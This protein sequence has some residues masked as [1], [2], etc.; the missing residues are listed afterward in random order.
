VR[1]YQPR[2]RSTAQRVRGSCSSR[3]K[4]CRTLKNLEGRVAPGRSSS[5]SQA[6]VPT[7]RSVRIAHLSRSRQATRPYRGARRCRLLGAFPSLVEAKPDN[8]GLNPSWAI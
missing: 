7:R 5:L 2:S 1:C 8:S 4:I 3:L 6:R